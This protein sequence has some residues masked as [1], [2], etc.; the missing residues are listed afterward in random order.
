MESVISSSIY[1]RL[2]TWQ[3]STRDTLLLAPSYFWRSIFTLP[4]A[5]W[6]LTA[7]QGC[8]GP[9]KSIFVTPHAQHMMV[10]IH[11]INYSMSDVL[12]GETHTHVVRYKL[13]DD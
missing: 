4:N 6:D 12:V 8:A 7:V 11:S 3:N 10:F 1:G 13:L 2:P 5:V 9:I